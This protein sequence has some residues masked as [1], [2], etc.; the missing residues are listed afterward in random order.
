[1]FRLSQNG[2]QMFCPEKRSEKW[3]IKVYEAG[4]VPPSCT[5]SQCGASG[6]VVPGCVS[7]GWE[8]CQSLHYARTF[9]LQRAPGYRQQVTVYL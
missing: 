1:M 4:S 2:S 7:P 8:A 6:C 3:K 9:G 5:S